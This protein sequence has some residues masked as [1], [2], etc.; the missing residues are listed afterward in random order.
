M[1]IKIST[2]LTIG[3]LILAF[4]FAILGFTKASNSSIAPLAISSFMG[5]SAALFAVLA[6][7]GVRRKEMWQRLLGVSAILATIYM[8]AFA[9]WFYISLSSVQMPTF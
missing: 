5:I 7:R 2:V 4:V 6:V 1:N 3:I 9:I 8:L